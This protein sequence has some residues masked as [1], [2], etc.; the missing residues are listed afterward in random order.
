MKTSH[1]GL[2]TDFADHEP[3]GVKVEINVDCTT[4]PMREWDNH[5]TCELNQRVSHVLIYHGSTLVSGSRS[6]D[7]KVQ[8]RLAE[9]TDVLREQVVGVK[10]DGREVANAVELED[11][12]HRRSSNVARVVLPA[13]PVVTFPTGVVRIKSEVAISLDAVHQ[14]AQSTGQVCVGHFTVVREV[15][16]VNL[17]TSA[18]SLGHVIRHNTICTRKKNIYSRNVTL[19]STKC[20]QISNVTITEFF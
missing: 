7:G 12:L 11:D 13:D 15:E 2:K 17:R 3:L 1:T 9:S 8:N 6:T 5:V 14:L 4:D 19:T 20:K 10:P 18:F 16:E